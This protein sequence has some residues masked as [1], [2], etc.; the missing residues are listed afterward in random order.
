MTRCFETTLTIDNSGNG[1]ADDIDIQVLFPAICSLVAVADSDEL[2]RFMKPEAPSPP[3]KPLSHFDS[4]ASRVPYAGPYNRAMI[5]ANKG[6]K[7]AAPIITRRP[8]GTHL[9]HAHIPRLKHS[10][11]VIVGV[12]VGAF[13]SWE[14]VRP[15]EASY[16]I[17]VAN[18]PRLFEGKLV[19][20]IRLQE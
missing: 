14:V 10:M 3:S 11:K 2:K 18:H 19:F 9:F 15:F 17:S 5:E 7:Y 12:V 16:A 4:L 20:K 8:G 13:K 6:D 1:P